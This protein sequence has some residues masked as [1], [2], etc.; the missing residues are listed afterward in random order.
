MITQI[1]V[2][3][4]A[5]VVRDFAVVIDIDAPRAVGG[6]G[7]PLHEILHLSSPGIEQDTGGRC[8]EFGVE[9]CPANPDPQLA[10][11]CRSQVKLNSVGLAA[12]NPDKVAV[13]G[14]RA[15]LQACLVFI[16]VHIERREA[17]AQ[18]AIEEIAFKPGL[19]GID[20]FGLEAIGEIDRIGGTLR[21]SARLIAAHIFGIKVQII[22]DLVCHCHRG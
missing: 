8:A 10:G 13:T 7:E 15:G 2:K 4:E 16:E 5:P 20:L 6:I 3:P 18:A 12:I 9:Q 21:S 14:G 1:R 11:D 22:V 19:E 17:Q